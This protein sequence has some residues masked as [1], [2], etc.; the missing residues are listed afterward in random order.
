LLHRAEKKIAQGV[1]IPYQDYR[2]ASA[3]VPVNK[4]KGS[5]RLCADYKGTVNPFVS[6]DTYRTPTVD[7][8]LNKLA[9]GC[10][11][12]EIDLEDAY[13]QICVDEETSRL[14]AVNTIKGLFRVT[15]LPFGVKVASAIF[16]RVIDSIL[17]KFKGVVSYQDNV[18]IKASSL[19]EYQQILSNVLQ[20]LSEAGLRVNAEK[21]TW[22]ATVI[23]VL[24]FKIS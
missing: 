7:E 16:Q 19:P 21:C 9:G 4:K 2:W 23:S 22:A 11:Y 10:I 5:L 18:Y 14:L 6:P 17:S 24:G 15:L 20:A 8:V 1:W 3:I 12:G 13:T